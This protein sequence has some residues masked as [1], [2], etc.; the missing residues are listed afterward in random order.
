[1]IKHL[2]ISG[3]GPLFFN[4]YG[5]IKKAEEVNIWS[6][7]NIETLHGTSA[8]AILC[9]ILA[10]DY[11]WD[12]LDNYIINRPWHKV[13]S[14]NVLNIYEYYESNGIL[15]IKFIEEVFIPLFK[16]LGIKKTVTFKEFYEIT[17]KKLYVYTTKFDTFDV[18]EFSMDETPDVSVLEAV[19]ASCT[20]PILFQPR[21]INDCVFIDGCIFLDNPLAKTIEKGYDEN[22]ILVISKK[23]REQTT[24][25]ITDMNVFDYLLFLMNALFTKTQIVCKDNVCKNNI[26]ITSKL[27]DLANFF[28]MAENP[29]DRETA[30]NRGKEDV[31][32]FISKQ[33]VENSQDSLA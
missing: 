10:L 3:G 27:S 5:A 19:Y 4:M 16:G 31:D 9:L 33:I 29:S 21:K 7:A 32:A 24:T 30:I 17:N 18:A 8:G 14:F 6:K 11:S 1:M 20:L 2:A 23:K 28:S 22:S 13:F 26:E 25:D 12:I 15:N